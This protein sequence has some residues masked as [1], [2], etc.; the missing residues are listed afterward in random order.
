MVD[1][2]YWLS[3]I[4]K[5]LCLQP[6][7]QTCLKTHF[8]FFDELGSYCQTRV[9]S[10]VSTQPFGNPGFRIYYKKFLLLH[11]PSFNCSDVGEF[12]FSLN[13]PNRPIQSIGRFVLMLC[14]CAIAENQPATSIM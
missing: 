8:P 5:G 9:G 12:K 7:Q 10:P 3:C 4:G 1:L 14:V 2:A 13:W 6:Q 11:I